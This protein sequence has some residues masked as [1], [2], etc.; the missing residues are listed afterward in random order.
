MKNLREVKIPTLFALAALLVPLA[1]QEIRFP[2]ST[3]EVGSPLVLELV[4]DIK[5]GK[6]AW[7]IEGPA[8]VRSAMTE[9]T[10]IIV[11]TGPGRIVVI[12]RIRTPQGIEIEKKQELEVPGNTLPAAPAA[13]PPGQARP[14][15][16]QPQRLA[17]P[18]PPPVPAD[19]L[20]GDIVRMGFVP[21]G[22]M[23]DAMKPDGLAVQDANRDTPHS[24]PVCT[25]V[26]YRPQSDRWAALAY[27]YVTDGTM[28]WGDQKGLNFSERGYQ[29]VRVWARGVRDSD[30]SMPVVTFLSGG[31]TRDKA[32]YPASYRVVGEAV[33]LTDN[34]RE[35]C[36]SLIGADLKNTTSPL[37]VTMTAANNPRDLTVFYLDTIFFS[38][39]ACGQ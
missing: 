29:S 26:T 22:Y 4:G 17:L 18:L 7:Q 33:E 23:G 28:N 9:K 16:Q 34:W 15:A 24:A 6:P 35:T 14:P 20:P 31:N 32:P 2:Q 37:T 11:P 25:R 27:Q 38:K 30:G 13:P 36:L 1:A 3:P 8:A 21:A 10:L 39:R 19:Y 12:C 5:D